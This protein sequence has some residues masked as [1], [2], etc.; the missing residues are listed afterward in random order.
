MKRLHLIL[1][2]LASFHTHVMAQW[3]EAQGEAKIING[4]ITQAREDAIAQALSYVTLRSGGQF[5]SVQRTQN[6]QLTQTELSL[7]QQGQVELISE[8]IQGDKLTLKLRVDVMQNNDLPSCQPQLKAAILVPQAQ[9][10]DRTQ[11]RYGNLGNFE[12][13][14]SEKLGTIIDREG[15]ASFA[16]VH[17]NERLDI[18]ESLIDIRGYRL[19]SWLSEITDSQ[20]ILL[21]EILD[22][23]TEPVESGL[24]GMWNNYPQR[25]FQLRLSLYHGISGE[26]IWSEY[27][28]A[29]APW[30][31]ERQATV[32]AQSNRFWASSYGK[33]IETLLSQ[34]GE[35]IDKVLNCRPILGQVVSRVD[36]RVIINL[37]RNHG[38]KVGDQ[39]QLVLQQNL[40]DRLDNMRAVASESRAKITI[41]QVTQESATA[42]L[43]GANG[44][45]NI[46]INDIAIK[47]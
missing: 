10:A 21:P 25:Q 38:V 28:D 9:I 19:P 15:K 32:P 44:A 35:D 24:F 36:N 41:E 40:P 2:L 11:L 7:S 47:I 18:E 3:L 12:K 39:F 5:T 16:H 22:I 30:E 1:L 37:G 27:Y 13:A 8:Q 46:Q 23:S 6:G 14:L 29:P 17:A 31:F 4:N 26:Q 33:N 43:Q 34:A 20:Y 45:I 42:L